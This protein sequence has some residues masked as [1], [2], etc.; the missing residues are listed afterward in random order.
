LILMAFFLMHQDV[1]EKVQMEINAV[2][3]NDRLPTMDDQSSL[4]YLDAVS[5][6]MFRYSPIAP[7]GE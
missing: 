2:V 1:Q 6:K 5:R 7:L 4:P 3:D